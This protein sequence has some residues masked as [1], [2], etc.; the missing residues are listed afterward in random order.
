MT[1]MEMIIPAIAG[2]WIGSLEYRIRSQTLL[3]RDYPQK[4]EVKEHVDLRLQVVESQ[5][6]E[7]KDDIHRMEK[8]LDKLLEK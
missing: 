6:R 1:I 7:L 8:K 4:A 3:L 5:M 2:L